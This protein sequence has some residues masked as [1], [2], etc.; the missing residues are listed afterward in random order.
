M[1]KQA[2]PTPFALQIRAEKFEGLGP[3][4]LGGLKVVALRIG[5]SMEAVLGA[6]IDFIDA[7]FP[8][9]FHCFFSA[10]NILV[11]VGIFF[12]LVRQHRRL[13]VFH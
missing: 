13:N 8:I 4:L 1:A 10:R 12:A 2:S 6:R 11:D 9:F 3:S 5:L 7:R